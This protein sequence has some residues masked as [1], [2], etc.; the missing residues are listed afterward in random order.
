MSAAVDETKAADMMMCCASCGKAAVDN[1][2]LKKCACNLVKYCSVDCQKN[3]RPQHKRAC[4]KRMAEIRDELLFTQPEGDPLGDCP[5]CFLP[6]PFDVTKRKIQPCC[7][8]IICNGCVY[9]N[10][11]REEEGN[12]EPKCPFCRHKVPKTDEE[13]DKMTAKRIESNDPDE[14][15][16]MGLQHS[17][18]GEYAEAFKYWAKA[19]ELKNVEAHYFLG[20]LYAEGHGVERDLKKK[21]YHLEIAAIG[22]HSDAR[23]NLAC[24]EGKK[25]RHDRA[26]KHWVIAAKLGNDTAMKSLRSG[27]QRGL[28]GKGD[29]ETA[30]RGHQAAV[31]A[32]K[33]PQRDLADR[34]ITICHTASEVEA[35]RT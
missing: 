18:K 20:L 24:V 23:Y 32:T 12:L 28:V 15:C 3:H 30:L 10:S 8:K 27:F 26:V 13:I 4:K 35:L 11:L 22:G 33:S 5:I 1:I 19:A 31:D 2:K 7:S 29:Y 21:I 17:G 9:A 25:G 6:M 16:E 34:M 14:L